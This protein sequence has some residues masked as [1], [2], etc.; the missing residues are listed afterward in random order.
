MVFGTTGAAHAEGND[1]VPYASKYLND[2]YVVLSAKGNGRMLITMGVDGVGVQDI[3]GVMYI[4]IEEKENGV[5]SYYDTLDCVEHDD[6]FAYNSRDYMGT[7]EFWGTP[8]LTYRV[9]V[10]VY[11]ATG[12]G[13]DTGYID[14]FTAICT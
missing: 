4:D 3:I 2:Y 10:H 1:I 13:S 9:R 12:S 5:W 11:A 7:A 8:G 14:S 6:F